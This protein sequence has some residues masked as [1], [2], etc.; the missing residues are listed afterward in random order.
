[1]QKHFKKQ[2]GL[3]EKF[4][5]M[6]A[7]SR[8][9]ILIRNPAEEDEGEEAPTSGLLLHRGWPGCCYSGSLIGAGRHF[10]I[11]GASETTRSFFSAT[12]D[13]VLFS[14]RLE[15]DESVDMRSCRLQYDTHAVRP[16]HFPSVASALLSAGHLQ[17][18]D[19]FDKAK[20]I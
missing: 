20:R 18:M 1:M 19:E 17:Q 8:K 11:K 6:A 9:L 10:H 16:R 15:F 7:R 12:D 4:E 13:I 5:G 14:A 3:N 2:I